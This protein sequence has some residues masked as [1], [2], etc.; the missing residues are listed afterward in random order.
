MRSPQTS[1]RANLYYNGKA[2]KWS[3]DL[4][5]D[6]LWKKDG[7]VEIVVEVD[8]RVYFIEKLTA[9]PPLVLIS[10]PKVNLPGVCVVLMVPPS[11]IGDIS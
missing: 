7:P 10:P 9:P 11:T 1:H 2:G 8:G 5:I 3:I 6:G 4:N